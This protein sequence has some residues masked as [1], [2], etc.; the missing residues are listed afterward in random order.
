M[1]Y[2]DNCAITVAK[3]SGAYMD[4]GPRFNQNHI[5]IKLQ[6]DWRIERQCLECSNIATLKKYNLLDMIKSTQA[7]IMRAIPRS[8]S[9]RPESDRTWF[10]W[11]SMISIILT[12]AWQYMA[13]ALQPKLRAS[14][15]KRNI[16]AKS[17]K[18]ARERLRASDYSHPHPGATRHQLEHFKPPTGLRIPYICPEALRY[19]YS[20]VF[21]SIKKNN[22]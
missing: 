11:I 18:H 16:I 13:D 10:S 3:G 9:R 2:Q 8:M 1:E 14:S 15:S 5:I 7:S 6:M 4:S 12:R 20:T 21:G 19:S 22:C 17:P